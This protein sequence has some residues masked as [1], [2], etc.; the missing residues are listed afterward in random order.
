MNFRG[1]FSAKSIPVEEQQMYYWPHNWRDKG[2]HNLSIG[3][4]PKVNA[5]A[6]LEFELAYY[7]VAV[8][9]VSHNARR[10]PPYMFLKDRLSE[11]W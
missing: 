3:I 9:Y 1:V 7:D 10:I 2:I 5:R 8:Q 4:S 11:L 6:Q